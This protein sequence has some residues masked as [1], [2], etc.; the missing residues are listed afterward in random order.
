MKK[1]GSLKVSIS[2]SIDRVHLVMHPNEG[3]DLGFMKV[4][5]PVRLCRNLRLEDYLKGGEGETE[6]LSVDLH[7]ECPRQTLLVG[8]NLFKLLGEPQRAV[9]LYDGR[10]LFI[11]AQEQ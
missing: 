11:H 7:N 3:F 10:R 2:S 8:R 1:T 4:A 6:D 9:L 5:H